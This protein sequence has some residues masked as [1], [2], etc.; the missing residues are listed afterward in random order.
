MVAL[1]LPQRPSTV[2]CHVV[3]NRQCGWC[4]S[5]AI[6]PTISRTLDRAVYCNGKQLPMQ[7]RDTFWLGIRHLPRLWLFYFNLFQQTNTDCLLYAKQGPG[8]SQD[9]KINKSV[10]LWEVSNPEKEGLRQ[11]QQH[12]L[13]KG[14]EWAVI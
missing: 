6:L 7:L 13:I 3:P 9:T 2:L 5:C 8:A 4:V 11:L 14:R 10:C 1:H 12:L